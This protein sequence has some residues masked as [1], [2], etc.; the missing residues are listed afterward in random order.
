[1]SN[2]EMSIKDAIGPASPN[3]RMKR[4][5]SDNMPHATSPRDSQEEQDDVLIQQAL[6]PENPIDF[7][8]ELEPGE[9]A[10]DAID[11]GDL[12][13]DDLAEDEEENDAHLD[14]TARSANANESYEDVKNFIQDE[15]LPQ[16]IDESHSNGDGFDD[17]FGEAPSSPINAED[18]LTEDQLPKTPDDVD[19]PFD[20]ENSVSGH[21]LKLPSL[22]TKETSQSQPQPQ[23]LFRPIAFNTDSSVLSKEQ[24]LQQELFAMSGSGSGMME[25][26]PATAENREQ[27]IAQLWPK[28]ER[29]SI[30]RLL[31][32]VPMK[33]AHYVGKT[34]LKRPR[35][36]QPTK[37][38][39][40]LG[41][42]QEKGFRLSSTSNERTQDE[43][44]RLG[45]V[46]ILQ[47]GFDEND[48]DEIVDLES[49]HEHE[50]LGGV[51]WQDL[52]VACEDWDINSWAES[53]NI[54]F[55][56]HEDDN[57]VYQDMVY[58]LKDDLGRS[59]TKVR[60]V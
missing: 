57:N 34:P 43:T 53:Q 51:T 23:N 44:D 58:V 46:R 27:M 5:Q 41:P 15:G 18:E 52:Q 2:Y 54:S 14:S 30:L 17:L 55:G 35:P 6:D 25:I 60:T 37:L 36:M 48:S 59:S 38:N 13:D 1:M 19:M 3:Q 47:I 21:L 11:F 31:D 49:D 33:K 9:K 24:Q 20:F 42:D 39:L 7:N 28:F 45:L 8:R 22:K 10:D 32:L 4:H 56:G 12:A 29:D 16:L 40:E 50:P 26:L